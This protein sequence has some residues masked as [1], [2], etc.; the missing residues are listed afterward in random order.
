MFVIPV[1]DL[2]DQLIELTLDGS[3]FYLRLMWNGT[4]SSWTAELSDSTQNLLCSGYPINPNWPLFAPA[5][6]SGMPAGGLF[7]LAPDRRDDISYL[8]LVNGIV[9]LYYAEQSD[10]FG[11]LT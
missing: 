3:T 11:G 8:D 5:P 10:I 2:N 6:P 4:M 1:Q 9:K 7:C